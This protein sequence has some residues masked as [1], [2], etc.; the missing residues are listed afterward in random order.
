MWVKIKAAVDNL[1]PD[2]TNKQCKDKMQNLKDASNL[3]PPYYTQFN[4]ILGCRDVMNSPEQ[5]DV[6]A[7]FIFDDE[8]N[9]SSDPDSYVN[10]SNILKQV[11]KRT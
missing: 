8:I 1:G 2:N 5:T 9:A 11:L 4:K 6:G 3:R 7:K 10:K